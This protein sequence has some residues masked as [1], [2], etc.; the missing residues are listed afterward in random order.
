MTTAKK[1]VTMCCVTID[2]RTYLLPADKGMKLVELLQSAF[3]CEKLYEDRGY[4]Y[5]VGVQPERVSLEI[6]RAGQI[7]Q[8]LTANPAGTRLLSAP[9]RPRTLGTLGEEE[10]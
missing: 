7:R 1:P 9:G 8:P 4:A 6:V 10:R 5:Q 2:F 3:E